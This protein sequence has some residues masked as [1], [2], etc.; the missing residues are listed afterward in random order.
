MSD[1]QQD[2]ADLVQKASLWR[3]PLWLISCIIPL[4]R[5]RFS[6][7]LKYI[8]EMCSRY[9]KQTMILNAAMAQNERC[10]C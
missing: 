10:A 6:L 5:D 3:V 8:C 7:C 2:G 1:S 9:T 4:Q